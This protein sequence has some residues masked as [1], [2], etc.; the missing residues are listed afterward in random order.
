MVSLP[1]RLD[2]LLCTGTRAFFSAKGVP[3]RW[4]C[5]CN[6]VRSSCPFHRLVVLVLR[7]LVGIGCGLAHRV[8]QLFTHV[9]GKPSQN[10]LLTITA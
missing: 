4:A 2:I 10:F 9:G 7:D 8:V 5:R 6:G 3:R 1:M